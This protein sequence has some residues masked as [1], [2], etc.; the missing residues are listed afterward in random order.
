MQFVIESLLE[1]SSEATNV[2]D[3]DG[4]LPL[5]VAI[6]N[7]GTWHKSGIRELALANPSVLRI[8]DPQ[9]GLL[10]FMASA[11]SAA[12]SR[13]HLSTTFE[14]LLA[15]PEMATIGKQSHRKN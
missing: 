9:T 11:T 4:R 1:E 14:L 8:A 3:T 6:A 7:S 13:L 10:P 5:H 12:K 15:A 2:A